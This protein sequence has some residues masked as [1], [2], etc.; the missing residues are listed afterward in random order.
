MLKYIWDGRN[1][2]TKQL[3]NNLL[4][5]LT[6]FTLILRSSRKD[7]KTEL[8][9]NFE[10]YSWNMTILKNNIREEFD[11]GIYQIFY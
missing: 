10:F 3:I 8:N 6:N 9:L 7:K 1:K 4:G 2:D 5:L 11:K